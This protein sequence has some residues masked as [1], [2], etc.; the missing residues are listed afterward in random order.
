MRA[1][2]TYYNG[3]RFRS[4]LEARWAVFFDTMGI[5]YEY[6]P[7]GFSLYNGEYYLPDF[8]LPWYRC[9]VEVKPREGDAIKDGNQKLEALFQT[10]ECGCILCIGEPFDNDMRLMC[11]EYNDSSGGFLDDMRCD[12]FVGVHFIDHDEDNPSDE[13]WRTKHHISLV[14]TD[15]AINCRD[16]WFTDSR[17]HELPI[18]LARDVID[19]RADSSHAKLKAR[20]ARFEYGECG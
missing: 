15:E 9:Y 5:E 3:Y 17:G 8:Y 13:A 6:E 2:E 12:F 7:E 19:Y 11:V 18:M 4:R 14:V 1:I 16:R 10:I 20:Q